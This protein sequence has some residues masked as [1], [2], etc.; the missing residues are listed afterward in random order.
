ML[1]CGGVVF[2]RTEEKVESMDDTIALADGGLGTVVVNKPNGV[3]K[4]ECFGDVIGYV[5]AAVVVE[6]WTNVEAF[7]SVEVPR[8][9]RGWIV[10]DYDWTPHGTNGCGIEVERTI[11][12]LPDQHGQGNV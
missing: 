7:A 1:D 5:E 6:C 9:S 3:R 2:Y 4:K 12:V 8:F 11:V 10:V